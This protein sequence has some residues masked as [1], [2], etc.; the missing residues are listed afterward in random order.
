MRFFDT[1]K[2]NFD[3]VGKRRLFMIL[4]VAV[5]IIG[6]ASLLFRGGLNYGIDFAGG[7]M[8]Q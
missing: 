2:L 5:I 3:F 8:V 4:S 6:L 7:T 1:D